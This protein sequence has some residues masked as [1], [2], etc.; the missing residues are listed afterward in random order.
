VTS[1]AAQNRNWSKKA[2]RNTVIV[3]KKSVQ[4]LANDLI[5]NAR[6]GAGPG[7]IPVVTGNL[8]NSLMASTAPIMTT[9]GPV[10]GGDVGAQI[11]TWQPETGQPLYLGW[12]AAYTRRINYGFT[13]ADKLG[14]VYNQGGRFFVEAHAARWQSYVDSAAAG[15]K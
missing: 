1:F 8:R 9:D 12:Q 13:G 2:M 6:S 14:R 7:N 10:V 3:M 11:L 15:F 5:G 4:N